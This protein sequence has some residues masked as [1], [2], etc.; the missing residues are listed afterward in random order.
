MARTKITSPK[1]IA[2]FPSLNKPDT[3][4]NPD[5]EYK[6]T[7]KL[8]DTAATQAYIAKIDEAMD[9]NM[10][11]EQIL[12]KKKNLKMA[13]KP[14][15]RDDDG[16]Y[17]I[18]FKLKANVK[19][20]DG[21]EFSQKPI[22][23]DAKKHPITANVGGGSVIRIGAEVNEWNTNQG[24]GVTLWVKLV[25]V[26]EL[27]EYDATDGF[28]IEEEDGWESMDSDSDYD[29]DEEERSSDLNTDGESEEDGDF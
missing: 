1:G 10:Q 17:F 23:I 22:L 20:R 7:L 27:K 6:V 2:V 18:K 4:Y 9:E 13:D 29:M 3:K 25:Q 15:S 8:Q 16:N 12:T 14:Y 26:L 19:T 24:V 21:K 11:R 5:G 28:D